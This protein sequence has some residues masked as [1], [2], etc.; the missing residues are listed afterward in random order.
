MKRILVV[1]LAALS[2]PVDAAELP[3]E[4]RGQFVYPQD[5]DACQYQNYALTMS[6][7]TIEAN[8]FSCKVNRVTPQGQGYTV[9]AT[10]SSEDGKSTKNKALKTDGNALIF[11]NVRYLRCD[12]TMPLA[13]AQSAP[14]GAVNN[15]PQAVP[16]QGTAAA[17]APAKADDIAKLPAACRDDNLKGGPKR[18]YTDAALKR[19]SK[20]FDSSG[21]GFIPQ[22]SVTAGIHPAYR[23]TI[24]ALSNGRD[25]PGQFYINANEWSGL[26]Q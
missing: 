26:C 13:A 9:N 4:V 7:S 20:D 8:E 19:P 23:G 25:Y 16:V 12:S 22:Q 6:A 18:I 14:A 11:D 10:C 1:A 24:F 3:P 2:F 15:A 21:T 5:A 17:V